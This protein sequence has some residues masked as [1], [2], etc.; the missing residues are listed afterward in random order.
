MRT[1]NQDIFNP[2]SEI[3]KSA[4]KMIFHFPDYDTLRLC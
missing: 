1:T 2:K 3:P 4:I